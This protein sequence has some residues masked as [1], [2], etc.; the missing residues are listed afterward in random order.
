MK[1]KVFYKY[2]LSLAL[3]SMVQQLVMNLSQ[4]MDNFMVGRLSEVS[5]SGV[6]IVNQVFFIFTTAVFGISAAGGVFITQYRGAK[7]DEKVTEV[8][9]IILL[10]TMLCGVLFFLLMHFFPTLVLS[11]FSKDANTIKV[12]IEYLS[13]IKFTF[14][15]YPFSIAIGSSLKYCGY[16]KTSMAVSVSTIVVNVCFNYCFI[17]GNL[18]F[19]ALG[20]MGSGVATLIA[21]CSEI[22]IFIFLTY[23]L[24]TPIKTKLRNLFKFKLFVLKD[25]VSKGYGLVLNELFWATGLQLLSVIFTQRISA[26]IAAFSVAN[27]LIDLIYIGMGGLSVATSIIIGNHLG[28]SEFKAAKRD[29]RLMQRLNVVVGQLFGFMIMIVAYFVSDL[30][31]ISEATLWMSRL[32]VGVAMSFSWL[33]YLNAN[34]FFTLR[35]GG[36]TRSILLLD[37]GFMWVV[38]MPIAFLLGQFHFFMPL[39]YFLVQFIDILKMVIS[40]HRYHKDEWLKNLTLHHEI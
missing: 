20:A 28:R 8:F 7:N 21:R 17:Y 35:T 32:M 18:G 38:M 40:R 33:Y 5:I 19:P 4:L 3:P 1:N 36:D 22:S 14:L 30:Y 6:A 27:A 2:A 26:N 16:V 39:H 29:A 37:S 11:A 13:M 31:A 25:F 12:A 34:Y 10:F 9:R 24:K 15:I 23:I